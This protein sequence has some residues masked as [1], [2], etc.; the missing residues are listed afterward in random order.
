MFEIL[1][2]RFP[3]PAPQEGFWGRP[4]S[5]LNWCE[6]DYVISHYAAEIMN[7]LTNVLFIALGVRGVRNCLKYKHDRIFL[8]AYMGYL[9]VGC[10]S[11]A[12]HA[13]LTYPMQLVD[14]LSM[15][16]TTC[17]LCY[18]I[19]THSKSRL[20]AILLGI[21]LAVLSI[22]ITAYY[23]YV[24]DPL[25]H[26][27]AFTILFITTVFRSLYTMESVLRPLLSEKYADKAGGISPSNTEARGFPVRGDH[28]IIREMR[29]IVVM[30]FVTSVAGI[31]AWNLDNLC[32][33]DLLR[34]RHQ[35][36][37]PWGIILEGHGWWHVLTALGVNYFI[38][39]GIW[40][41]HCLNDLQ[42]HYILNWPH[43]LLSLPDVVP[44][45][46]HPRY[47]RLQCTMNDGFGN[48]GLEKKDL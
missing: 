2:V 47:S 26:Q 4:T 32:C 23:H 11:F 33:S 29:W 9:L 21:G 48:A 19:F 34:W 37:L 1:A 10:G 27:C 13:T 40:L 5:T 35:V 16:Y 41:R 3:Y 20:F 18:A 22:S 14:E 7:T 8:I 36:G 31:A 38:T 15:I 28:V 6:E 24:K 30:G 25:F 42:E 17:I 43:K 45:V 44:S 12:F 39:W 46:E